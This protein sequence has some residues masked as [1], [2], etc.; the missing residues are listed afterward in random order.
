MMAGNCNRIGELAGFH[1][2]NGGTPWSEDR[3]EAEKKEGHWLPLP[4]PNKN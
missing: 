3:I 4:P 2:D 1:I